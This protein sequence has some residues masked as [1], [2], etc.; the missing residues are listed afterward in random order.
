MPS[1]QPDSRLEQIAPRA[2][3]HD[4]RLADRRV[5]PAE[6]PMQGPVGMLLFLTAYPPPQ[7]CTL[8]RHA[9]RPSRVKHETASDDGNSRWGFWRTGP[10]IRV[11]RHR[12]KSGECHPDRW[13]LSWLTDRWGLSFIRLCCKGHWTSS[14]DEIGA[15]VHSDLRLWGERKQG[16]KLRARSY[17]GSSGLRPCRS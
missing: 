9:G 1:A 10:I 5:F 8:E 13:I 12:S 7:R 6:T 15:F 3:L 4:P 14:R 11:V 17:V 16:V 2:D